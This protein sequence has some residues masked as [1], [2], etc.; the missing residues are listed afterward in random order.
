MDR[1][2][3]VARTEGLLVALCI[4]IDFD[5]ANV[6]VT[7]RLQER[8]VEFNESQARSEAKGRVVLCRTFCFSHIIT[9]GVALTFKH[10]VLMPR[11]YTLAF[12]LRFA[13]RFSSLVRR[14]FMIVDKDLRNGGFFGNVRPT[15]RDLKH[16]RAILRLTLL[17][18]LYTKGRDSQVSLVKQEPELRELEKRLLDAYQGDIRRNRTE[19]IGPLDLRAAV[20]AQVMSVV[21][22]FL[23]PI[24]VS[25]QAANKWWTHERSLISQ[26]G[27]LA[28]HNLPGG[29]VVENFGDDSGGGDD[30]EQ[31]ENEEEDDFHNIC[32]RRVAL[33]K[34]YCED[35]D[36]QYNILVATW[37]TEPTDKLDSQLQHQDL[38]QADGHSLIDLAHP[39]GSVHKCQQKLFLMASGSSNCDVTLSDFDYHFSLRHDAWRYREDARM[40][41]LSMAAFVWA[42][43]EITLEGAPYAHASFGDLRVS[44]DDFKDVELAA[45]FI[46]IVAKL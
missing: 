1:W 37:T 12:C 33:A 43:L 29:A 14:L 34:E 11:L 13:P 4:A 25:L 39:V 10:V 30:A 24:R 20:Y 38:N 5:P 16:T 23:E 40:S 18:P 28:F 41:A 26:G 42:R 9:R 21:H 35:P 32:K 6:R 45:V 36:H 27:G 15:D 17:R 3:D 44:D 31:L 19:Y 22:A 46:V 2:F 8:I 7:M